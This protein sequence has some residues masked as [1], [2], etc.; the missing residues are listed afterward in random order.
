MSGYTLILMWYAVSQGYKS[1]DLYYPQVTIHTFSYPRQ[2][3]EALK[4]I[5]QMANGKLIEG[6]C[7]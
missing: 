5:K 6:T 3:Q 1:P 7:I 2:C 4:T